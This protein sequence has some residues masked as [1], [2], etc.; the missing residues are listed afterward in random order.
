[1]AKAWRKILKKLSGSTGLRGTRMMQAQA[2]L[3]EIYELGQASRLI[4]KKPPEWVSPGYR[5]G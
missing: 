5:A 3:G 1:M 2:A 4:T